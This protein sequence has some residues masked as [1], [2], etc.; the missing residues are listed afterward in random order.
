MI[1]LA[2]RHPDAGA[3]LALALLPFVLLFRA[4]LP[5]KV[6]SPADN[7]LLSAPWSSLAPGSV[8]ANPLQVDVTFMLHPW[9]LYAAAEI[10]RGHFPLW[11]PYVFAGAPFFANAESALLFPLTAL[12]YVLP[13]A[14]ALGLMSILKLSAAGVAM[15]WFLRVLDLAHFPA[16]L[17][18]LAF[19][20]NASLVAW[21]FWPYASSMIFLP[22]LSGM[23]ERLRERPGPRP[24]AGLAV[25]VALDIFAGY[26]QGLFY[27]VLTATAWAF[28]RLR[29]PGGFAFL[30]RYG[31]GLALGGAL[32]AVQLLPFLEYMRESAVL[33]YRADWI[34][35]IHLPLRA[36]MTFLL[37]YY[38]GSPTTYDFWGAWNFNEMAV[39]V[40]I[41]PWVALP[42]ALILGW[43]RRGTKLLAAL[44]A[45]AA[46]VIYGGPL[47]AR[48]GTIPVWSW[49]IPLRIVPLL[50]FPLCVLGAIGLDA[51]EAA[52]PPSRRAAGLAVRLF[53]VLLSGLALLCL[54]D[55][56]P[57][58][59]RRNLAISPFLQYLAFLVLLTA[60]ALA[61]IARLEGLGSPVT[62]RAALLLIQ[63]GG[64]VSL[65]A[66]YN[67]VVDAVWLRA[68]TPAIEYLERDADLGRVVMP[69]NT[70]IMYRLYGVAGYDGMSPRRL[71]E[72]LKPDGG[73][74]LT[75]SG[76][77]RPPHV[78]DSG[79]ADF[80]GVRHVLLPPV[81]EK[82]GWTISTQGGLQIRIQSM[83]DTPGEGY[84]L[85]YSGRDARIYRS[86]QALPRATLVGRARCADDEASLRL[87]L[88][89]A[90]DLGREALIAPCDGVDAG[91]AA[92]RRGTA[93]IAAYE[94]ERVLIRAAAD[95]PAYLVLSDSWFPGWRVR[96]DGA[97]RPLLRANHAFRAVRLEPG[98]HEVEFRYEPA[99]LRWG[100]GLSLAAAVACIV[101]C[102]PVRRLT[103]IASAALLAGLAAAPAAEAGL[104]RAPFAFSVMPSAAVDAAPGR[105]EITPRS[106][107]V[108]PVAFDLY[109]AQV[110]EF[111]GRKFLTPAGEWSERP[112]PYRTGLAA[113]TLAPIAG[114]F[115]QTRTTGVLALLAVG[116]KPGTSPQRRAN[117]AFEPAFSA[118]R[119]S[120]A[121]G[122]PDARQRALTLLGLGGA[123]V[124][125]W[126]LILLY[127]VRARKAAPPGQP[128]RTRP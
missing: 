26:P 50:V 114:E 5:G 22:L 67:P 16:F 61:F 31:A 28:Y 112:V 29:G 93:E 94:A 101:L 71:E 43:R 57:V 45:L 117:W 66:T 124:V 34:A 27:G 116:V 52:H 103:R 7:L 72:V 33:R 40:G 105:F 95:G 64:S 35:P 18:G 48:L 99:S 79:L 76:P 23:T 88:D 42:A 74:T 20:L 83:P 41:V 53:C 17:G 123:T 51:A 55:D 69:T 127:P 70:S 87:M 91:A 128:R 14:L 68:S 32:G 90:V 78:L 8:A 100:L 6:L 3:A 107:G 125:A 119:V 10:G 30:F 25:L 73:L 13:P 84:V 106:T 60:A 21:L 113:A 15:Y 19:M 62:A 104:P 110:E 108:P 65:A 1:G 37:P 12:A 54:A 56:Y 58:L 92:G 109:I 82:T 2:R 98:R 121:P 59:V 24:V 85:V 63:L 38:Y 39:S 115:P 77:I 86:L 126:G 96:V 49:V 81:D 36:A 75:G 118:V 102:L 46:L 47:T 89:R 97:E 111:E 80:L 4:L 9:T 11:N 120:A 122:P 44:A